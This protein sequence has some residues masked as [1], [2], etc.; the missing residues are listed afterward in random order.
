MVG[1]LYVS[2]LTLMLANRCF[3]S[4]YHDPNYNG[5]S[6]GEYQYYDWQSD[7]WD[8]ST[9]KTGRCAKMDCHSSDTEWELIGVYKASVEFDKDT[10]FEQL[11][12][13]EG[14]SFFATLFCLAA[15]GFARFA[16]L[17]DLY[18]SLFPRVVF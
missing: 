7:K 8:Q 15:K 14:T 17:N 5:G 12:K 4:Q 10:F 3:C 1:F 16:L 2:R 13:H 18:V 6:I 11:F 9:C